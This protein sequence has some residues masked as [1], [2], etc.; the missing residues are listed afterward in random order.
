MYIK[1]TA[2]ITWINF[3]N[4]GTFLQAYALQQVI[5]SIGFEHTII[6]DEIIVKR[7][8]MQRHGMIFCVKRFFYN[9]YKRIPLNNCC[10]KGFEKSDSM[11]KQFSDN[12][13]TIDKDWKS[14]KDLNSRYDIFI[15]GSDQIWSPV[16]DIFNSF[17]YLSFTDKKK[18]AYA[19]SI[20]VNSYPEEFRDRV[21]SL[22][23]SFSNISVREENGAKLLRSF[24]NKEITTVLDP[25][26]LLTSE[27]WEKIIKKNEMIEPYILCYL[28]TYNQTYID[29]V[30]KY[31]KERNVKLK[32]FITDKRYLAYADIPLF[33]GPKEFLG[34]IHGT[35]YFFTD[36]FHGTIFAI[37]FKK[38]FAA[39]KRFKD[40]DG[41]N[42][43]SRL[44]NLFD[45]LNLNNYFIAEDGLSEITQ[46]PEI[47]YN[48]V[49]ATLNEKREKS[50]SFLS[51][52]L[53][54]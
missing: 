47:D 52:A 13:L 40:A 23:E 51:N 42:Q 24:V 28:L 36:S 16:K 48:R 50:I 9:I 34:E 5:K 35:S 38:R 25:T 30:Y 49:H 7:M 43:N 3:R 12:F 1:R 18:V 32:F 31:A 46:L 33:V 8:M 39:F 6:S 29:F 14:A 53:N 2:T 17:Y 20:G 26:L 45:I 4:F 19:P 44:D 11:Y 22:L 15:C 10:V 27:Q 54:G 21:K 41:K 37:Q